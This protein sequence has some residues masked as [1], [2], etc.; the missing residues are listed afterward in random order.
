VTSLRSGFWL[1]WGLPAPSSMTG[2][3]GGKGVVMD[4]VVV[5]RSPF[6]A[7]PEEIEETLA[8]AKAR[9]RD[10]YSHLV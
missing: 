6:A 1:N 8:Y 9:P 10:G 3:G 7:L 5:P 2:W 4:R